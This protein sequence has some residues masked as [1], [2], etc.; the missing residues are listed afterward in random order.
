VFRHDTGSQSTH[1]LPCFSQ[2]RLP[3]SPAR[4]SVFAIWAIPG[5]IL[6]ALLSG[7]G[8]E[9]E[10]GSFSF[11]GSSSLVF[12]PTVLTLL[13]LRKYPR[14]WFDWNVAVTCFSYRVSSFC[15]LLRD[16]MPALEEEQSVHVHVEPPDASRLHRLLPL[17]KWL[18]ALPHIVILLVLTIAV[19]IVA[20]CAWVAILFT[21]RYPRSM[22]DFNVGVLRWWLRVSAYAFL[23]TTDRY[24][25]FSLT[26]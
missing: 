13:V 23:L 6:L 19:F 2:R 20:V 10:E 21:G 5:I 12:L 11:D 8:G 25:P 17:V 14:W 1:S 15:L 16:E 3:R 9:S 26:E 22:F 4:S 24:P 18:L 7:S